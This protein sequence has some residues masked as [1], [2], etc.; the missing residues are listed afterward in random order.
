MRGE[1]RFEG[2]PLANC[3]FELDALYHG[4]A[5]ENARAM[6]AWIKRNAQHRCEM[7]ARGEQPEDLPRPRLLDTTEWVTLLHVILDAASMPG[8]ANPFK[9]VNFRLDVYRALSTMPKSVRQVFTHFADG[10]DLEEIALLMGRNEEMQE[11]WSRSSVRDAI[12]KASRGVRRHGDPI[13]DEPTKRYIGVP[14]THTAVA[15]MSEMRELRTRRARRQIRN[16]VVDM[17]AR[18]A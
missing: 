10:F 12:K 6:R 3:S 4:T 5:H 14:K 18:S 2:G 8:S 1:G 11:G 15:V 7:L 17:E 9:A 13:L 16:V